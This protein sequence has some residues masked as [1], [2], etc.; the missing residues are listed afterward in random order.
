MT[1][2]VGAQTH[3]GNLTV[4]GSDEPAAGER[5][6]GSNITSLDDRFDTS[7][8]LTPHSD[9]VAQ[10]VHAHQTQAHNLM[11]LANYQTRIA[12]FEQAQANRASGRPEQEISAQTRKRIE[13][14]AEQLVRY[15]LFADEAPLSDL[16]RG[17]S[18][19]TEEFQA[20]GPRDRRGRSL[21]DFDL[22]TRLFK[23][24]L[25]YL[26]YTDAFDALPDLAKQ[27]VYQRLFDVLTSDGTTDEFWQ[28]DAPTR[29][30]LFE[31]L[32]DTKAGLPEAWKTHAH[33][34]A[35]ATTS[36]RNATER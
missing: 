2:T 31:I 35:P 8:Y 11:T 28:L 6:A 26:V 24:P 33:R 32:L 15:L 18:G 9:I 36:S 17:T 3:L 13:E 4:S 1:G 16:V 34:P 29:R 10:L 27:Y 20:R 25:S 14:P 30:A 23:Y 5:T 19:F 21:R 7:A 22:T 12:L